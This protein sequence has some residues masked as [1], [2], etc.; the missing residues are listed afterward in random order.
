MD[1]DFLSRYCYIMEANKTLDTLGLLCPLPVLKA[2][3]ALKSMDS[4]EVLA[5]LADDP[6]AEIDVPHFCTESGHAFLGQEVA[7][8]GT[9]YFIGCK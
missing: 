3:K 9:L 5:L 6:A 8:H 1:S 7:E 4:S 2:Q